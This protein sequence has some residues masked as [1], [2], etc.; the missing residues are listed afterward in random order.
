[1][2]YSSTHNN[3]SITIDIYYLKKI[4]MQQP[5]PSFSGSEGL[6][7]FPKTCFMSSL[8]GDEVASHPGRGEPPANE[9]IQKNPEEMLTYRWPWCFQ[10][11]NTVDG[12]QK[13]G[14]NSP[15]DVGGAGFV[16]STVGQ[17]YELGF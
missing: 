4:V 17:K 5:F 10:P 1:M 6:I 12:N 14:I 7:P 3:L 8:C 15:V 11:L 13:S 9:N 16:P 2:V